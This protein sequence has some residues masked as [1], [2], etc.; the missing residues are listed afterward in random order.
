MSSIGD[1]ADGIHT[2]GPW[3]STC[4]GQE[5]KKQPKKK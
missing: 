5:K 4:H 3:C 2:C 1:T